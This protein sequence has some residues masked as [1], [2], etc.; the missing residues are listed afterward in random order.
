[1]ID[2]KSL[3]SCRFEIEQDS[4]VVPGEGEGEG[5][6]RVEEISFSPKEAQDEAVLNIDTN[7]KVNEDA[8]MKAEVFEDD[9]DED[10]ND[11]EK[12]ILILTSPGKE[13]PP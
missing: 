6:K 9:E 1:M 11:G 8:Q 3:E 7:P 5:E 12:E 13:K 10:E 4:R 2:K